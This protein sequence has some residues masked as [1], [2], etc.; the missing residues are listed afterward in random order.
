MPHSKTMPS[1]NLIVDSWLPV[2]VEGKPDLVGIRWALVNS[3]RIQRLAVRPATAWVAVLRQ[4]L[5]PLVADALGFPSTFDD[6][7]DRHDNGHFDADTLDA[8]L[9]EHRDRFNVFDDIAPFAQVAGLRT[10]KDELKS[11]SLLVPSVPSGNNVPLFG[12]RTDA[13]PP[14]L[15]WGEAVIGLLTVQC[16]DTAGIKTGAVGDPQVKAGKTTANPIGPLGTLGVIVPTGPTLF[17]TLMLNLLIVEEA[18]STLRKRPDLP[19]W[20]RKQ[21]EASWSERAVDGYRDSWTFQARRVR[22][23]PSVSPGTG[24]TVVTKVLVTAGD[25]LRPNPDWEPHSAWKSNKKAGGARVPIRHS[26]GRAAW[27]GLDPLIAADSPSRED[28]T[29]SSRLLKQIAELQAND[30]LPSYYPLGVVTAGVEYGNMQ[31]VVEN[32]IADEIPLPITALRVGT[33]TASVVDTLVR[34]TDELVKAIDELERNVRIAT[35]SNMPE[36]DKGQRA[37]DRLVFRLDDIARRALIG[38]QRE[39]DRA[40]EARKAWRMAARAV[41]LNTA[42]EVLSSLPPAAVVGRKKNDHFYRASNAE[43]I[44]LGRLRRALPRETDDS[45]GSTDQEGEGE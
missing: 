7:A 23:V 31:A 20:R 21:A 14:V 26:S 44:F 29:A 32:I 3:H 11:S 41:C 13:Q 34:D 25:R 36:R 6:W 37:S 15:S 30:F 12:S 40:D 1:H 19:Q 22:L 16:W 2:I 24:E 5:L 33:P 10:S 4:A 43:A 45:D 28:G 8:Y 18:P 27:R 35:G 38:L 9:D 17:E 39:P 42:D